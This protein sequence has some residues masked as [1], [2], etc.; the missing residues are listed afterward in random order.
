MRILVTGATGFVGINTV[1]RLLEKHDVY[2][3]V[4]NI[5]AAKKYFGKNVNIA[6]GDI[7]DVESLK[8]AFDKNFD[9][10]VHIAGVI[11]AHNLEKLY[12]VNRYGSKNVAK[13][14]HEA[15][16]KKFVYVSSLS[17][18]G[19]DGF[20]GPISHY[21][22]SKRLGEFEILNVYKFGNVE[23][24]R[25]PIIFGPYDKGT[26]PFFKL[27]QYGI[28]P[29]MDRTYSLL[30]I[31]DLVKILI[32]LLELKVKG[33]NIFYASSFTVNFEEL[34]ECLLKI[35]NKKVLKIK[36]P[37]GLMK[38]T[39]KFSSKRSPFTVDKVREIVPKSWTCNND[40]IKMYINF[41][42]CFGMCDSL[43]K[44]YLWYKK[45]GWI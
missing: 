10:V 12:N 11:S 6:Y 23:I 22:N 35:S 8:K 27:A 42:G 33:T 4:R 43:K 25:P 2:V 40:T 14:A 38:L 30:F 26:L 7:L 5:E 44:T 20:N 34:A 28:A 16:V 29:F 36:P 39:A 24:F 3:F 9:S 21:G 15:G 17:A 19:P 37:V 1:K 18:R 45:N 13:V 41:E 32:G 31:E